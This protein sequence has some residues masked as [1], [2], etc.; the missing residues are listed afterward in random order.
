MTLAYVRGVV[1][2]TDPGAVVIA[3]PG[4]RRV[5]QH[6]ALCAVTNQYNEEL[7][8]LFG[9]AAEVRPEL[10]LGDRHDTATL[11]VAADVGGGAGRDVLTGSGQ[12]DF[13][14]GGGGAGDVLRGGGSSDFLSDG[15]ADGSADPDLLDGGPGDGDEVSY[16]K[17]TR[18]VVVD[19]G[20]ERGGQAGEGDRI[21]GM[22]DMAGGAAADRL[23]GSTGD[24]TLLGYGGDD[25]LIGGAG[26]DSVFGGRGDDRIELG[27]GTDSVYGG[28]GADTVDCGTGAQDYFEVGPPLGALNT[29]TGCETL[30]QVVAAPEVLEG[31]R[32]FARFFFDCVRLTRRGQL[33]IGVTCGQGSY[34]PSCRLSVR[35]RV[36]G[37]RGVARGTGIPDRN[38]EFRLRI[39]R[40]LRGSLRRGREIALSVS[41]AA[42][43]WNPGQLVKRTQRYRARVRISR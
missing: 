18:P 17:R 2:F 4:C 14:D 42:E 37:R 23:V 40:A 33:E 27:A 25:L 20:A 6:R 11:G 34:T 26:S 12:I 15:D 13:L 9:D 7:N 10:L 28:G 16:V 43:P 1:A 30:R 8:R 21:I 5:D 35:A 32:N 19:V 3:G 31:T 39:P 38:G 22:E 36:P 41:V 24:N 29:L